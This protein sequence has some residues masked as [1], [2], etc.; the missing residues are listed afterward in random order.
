MKL[1][2][3]ENLER[4]GIFEIR[5]HFFPLRSITGIGDLI[6]KPDKM[7]DN[8]QWTSMAHHR[9]SGQL[10]YGRLEL[11]PVYIFTLF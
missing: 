6:E 3:A 10:A 11:L 1:A 9:G 5:Q 7:L 2:L 4:N 8:L